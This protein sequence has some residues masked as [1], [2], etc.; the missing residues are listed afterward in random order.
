ML[1][2]QYLAKLMR[3]RQG[4]YG[5]PA[6]SAAE[7]LKGFADAGASHMIIR[8]VGDPHHQL[9]AV[10]AIRTQLGWQA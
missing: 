4:V 6:A 10:T 8:F 7:F 9:E 5:G 2:A 3:R 1:P